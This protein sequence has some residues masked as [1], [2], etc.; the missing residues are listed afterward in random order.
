MVSTVYYLNVPNN[1][2]SHLKIK[3]DPNISKYFH[4]DFDFDISESLNK[5]NNFVKII[6]ILFDNV[7]D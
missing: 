3:E 2:S 1:I 6:D 7:F 4:L 5:T